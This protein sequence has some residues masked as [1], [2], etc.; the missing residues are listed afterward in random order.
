M[1]TQVS[2]TA[3]EHIRVSERVK[4]ALE[5]RK[6]EDESFNDVLERVLGTDAETD[7][8]DGFGAWSDDQADRVRERRKRGKEKRKKRMRR[9]SGDDG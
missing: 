7:F 9:L 2:E 4:S 8:Y 6:R 3:D 5:R 1:S